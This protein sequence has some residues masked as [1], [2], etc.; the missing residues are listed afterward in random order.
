MKKK[1]I[2][3]VL[4]CLAL[5]ISALICIGCSSNDHSEESLNVKSIN[6]SISIDYPEK[7]KQPDLKT[8]PFRLE[9]GTSGLQAVEL[10]GNVN[11]TSVLVDTTY[12]T[13]EGIDSI[14][15]HV[16]LKAGEWQ[17]KING[18]AMDKP[19]GDVILKDGDHLELIYMKVKAKE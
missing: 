11:N 6:I 10:Y 1:H 4:V 15:N 5:L 14:I 19:I 17:Y 16:T 7:A 9:E 3:K 2:R 8:L 12:S 18:K 13:L